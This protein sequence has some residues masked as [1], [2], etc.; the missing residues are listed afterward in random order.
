MTDR[1]DDNL[2]RTDPIIETKGESK[3]ASDPNVAAL[4]A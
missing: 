3:N 2:A 4:N 1:N